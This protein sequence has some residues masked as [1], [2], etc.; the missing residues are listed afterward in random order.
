MADTSSLH[1]FGSREA[2]HAVARGVD[3][4]AAA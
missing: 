4:A 2:D 3:H 1:G